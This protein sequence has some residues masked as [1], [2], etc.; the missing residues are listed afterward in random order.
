MRVFLNRG[1][2]QKTTL[3]NSSADNRPSSPNTNVQTYNRPTGVSRLGVGIVAGV[4]FAIIGA[5][6]FNFI[7]Q[8]L[9]SYYYV[10][11]IPFGWFGGFGFGVFT[12]GNPWVRGLFGAMFGLSAMLLGLWFVYTTP[13]NIEGI[14]VAASSVMSYSEFLDPLDYLS[15]LGGIVAAF[16][17]GRR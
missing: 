1:G 17:A 4:V 5:F 2:T 10:L 3:V 14:N 16:F 15:I 9:G 7:T 13:I 6:I 11:L 12:K 8:V